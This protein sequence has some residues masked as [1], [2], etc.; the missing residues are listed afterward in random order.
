MNTRGIIIFTLVGAAI[1]YFII[2]DK[3]LLEE[4]PDSEKLKQRLKAALLTGSIALGA[5]LI[6]RHYFKSLTPNP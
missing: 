2:P 4:L 1:G 6:N 3:G 5:A